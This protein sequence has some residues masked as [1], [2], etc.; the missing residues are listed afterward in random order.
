MIL[1]TNKVYDVVLGR[2]EAALEGYFKALKGKEDVKVVVMDLSAT[3]RNIVRN[4]FQM[5]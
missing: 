4:T 1:L 5:Q 2:T 3:Y